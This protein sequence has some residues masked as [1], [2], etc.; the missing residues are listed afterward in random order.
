MRRVFG[1]FIMSL[2]LS[3]PVTASGV[4]A[5]RISQTIRARHLPYGVIL[6]PVF[7]SPASNEIV[8]YARAGDSA[9]WTGHYLAAASFRY[10]VT[11]SPE[12]LDEVRAALDGIRLLVDVTNTNLLARTLYPSDSPYAQSIVNDAGQNGLYARDFGDRKYVW[13][14]NTSRD[15]YSGAFFGLGVAY[16]IV[17]DAAVRAEAAELISRML[18]FLINH[19][20]LVTMPDGKISTVFTANPEQRLTFL[21]LGRLVDPD[22]F[23]DNYNIERTTYGVAVEAQIAINVTNVTDSYYKFNLDTINLYTLIRFEHSSF[24][25]DRYMDAYDLLRRTTDDHGNAHFN[26]ID[27]ALKG[28][29][30]RR[31]AETVDL[32]DQWLERPE[33]DEWRDWRNNPK[34]PACSDD[35]ACNP[36]PVIDRICTDFLW[37]RSPFLLWGGGYGT[38]EGAGVDY[39]LPYWMARYYGVIGPDSRSIESRPISP[40]RPRS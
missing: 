1:V 37:Q 17:D 36:I 31:D 25:H 29:D 32:L 4:D 27:R 26:M 22:R 35:S 18:S 34:Y 12:A 10:A 20:W 40:R 21:Q 11:R 23:G 15:Q 13:I 19:N 2:T 3:L 24:F 28:P 6:D 38:I 7:S 8:G 16:E 9:V 39:L 5:L 33:R 14:G 30:A